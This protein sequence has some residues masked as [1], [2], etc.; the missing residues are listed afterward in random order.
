M[1]IEILEPSW[2]FWKL[3]LEKLLTIS[4]GFKWW[5]DIARIMIAEWT[6]CTWQSPR[7][8]WTEA[9]RISLD[10]SG[11]STA[12]SVYDIRGVALFFPQGHPVSFYTCSIFIFPAKQAEF[13]HCLRGSQM[14]VSTKHGSDKNILN[15]EFFFFKFLYLSHT[16]KATKD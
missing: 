10:P 14:S 1:S 2:H 6:F 13:S 16:E 11:S 8:H 9:I 12:N 5:R 15:T 3:L 7:R 4:L